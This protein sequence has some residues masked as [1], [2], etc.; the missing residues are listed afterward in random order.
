MNSDTHSSSQGFY[1]LPQ[2]LALIPVS[3]SKWWQG[4]ASLEYPQPVKLSERCTAWRRTD[5][6]ALILKLSG[7]EN[8][9]R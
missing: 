8:A 5:I 1:R 7:G 6:D 4:V 9:K 3:R 2:I